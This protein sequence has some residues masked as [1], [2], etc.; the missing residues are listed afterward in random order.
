[1][2]TGPNNYRHVYT[3]DDIYNAGGALTLSDLPVGKYHVVENADNVDGYECTSA[4]Y[5]FTVDGQNRGTGNIGGDIPVEKNKNSEALFTNNYRQKKGALKLTKEFDGDG[6]TDALK[7][8][9]TFTIT[10]PNNYSRTVTYAEIASGSITISDLPVGNYTIKENGVASGNGT[11]VETF[12]NGDKTAST[13]LQTTASVTDG[14]TAQ[15]TYKNVYTKVGSLKIIGCKVTGDKNYKNFREKKSK[16]TV[17]ITGPNGYTKT[18]TINST[19]F[20]NWS[21]RS[22]YNQ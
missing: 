12:I 15:T 14:E 19:N 6:V 2:V 20:G 11:K 10:G 13:T 16:A 1:M 22:L 5:S 9:V 4:T 3:Y 18:V 8:N 7:N 17:T 21:R